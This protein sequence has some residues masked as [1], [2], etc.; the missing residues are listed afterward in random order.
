MEGRK[1]WK[2]L[3]VGLVLVEGNLEAVLATLIGVALG[4]GYS[5]PPLRWRSSGLAANGII[6]LGVA[7]ALIGGMLAQGAVPV[8]GMVSAGILGWLAAAASMV[9]DFKDVD[10]DQAAGVGTLPVILGFR[11]AVLVN[12]AMVVCGYAPAV[13]LLAQRV[14]LGSWPMGALVLLAVVNLGILARLLRDPGAAP[15]SYRQALLLFMGVTVLYV[16]TQVLA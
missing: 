7:C 10:G 1:G 15:A 13:A 16:G 6:G 5:V 3:A 2:G 4:L 11:R 8:R 12:M 9:K 14:G